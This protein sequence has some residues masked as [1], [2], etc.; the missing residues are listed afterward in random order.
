MFRKW[1]AERYH[2]P[3][4]D[5]QQPWVPEAAAK[6]NVFFE[7]LVETVANAAER[8]SWSAGSAYAQPSVDGR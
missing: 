8:P 2:T 6:F 1:Y 7:K 5:L 4:D 3:A